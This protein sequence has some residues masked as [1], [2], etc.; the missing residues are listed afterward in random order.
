M[1]HPHMEHPAS[2]KAMPCTALLQ[3][4]VMSCWTVDMQSDEWTKP[5]EENK[6]TRNHSPR[7]TLDLH[8][9]VESGVW[10]GTERRNKAEETAPGHRAMTPRVL[11]PTDSPRVNLTHP[12]FV[13]AKGMA[14]FDQLHIR[15]TS[16]MS[17]HSQLSTANVGICINCLLH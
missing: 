14:G 11:G 17:L 7:V 5:R 4:E 9:L 3:Q 1:S 12:S 13:S 15:V 8:V 10:G 16:I 2:Q 6:L